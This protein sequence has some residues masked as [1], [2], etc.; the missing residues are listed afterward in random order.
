VQLRFPDG[1]WLVG[2]RAGGGGCEGILID[3]ARDGGGQGAADLR[4]RVV[5]EDHGAHARAHLRSVRQGHR[6]TGIA[7]TLPCRDLI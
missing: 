1:I 2:C 5:L 3:L 7:T 6:G 4:R